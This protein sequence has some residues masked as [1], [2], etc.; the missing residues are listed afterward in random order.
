[1]PALKAA[2]FSLPDSK[3][4]STGPCRLEKLKYN[5]ISLNLA[6]YLLKIRFGDYQKGKIYKNA[7]DKTM[8][9]WNSIQ[10]KELF[11]KAGAWH[12]HDFLCQSLF[13]EMNNIKH[14]CTNLL[15]GGSSK[16]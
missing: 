1:M 6:Q 3:N 10:H 15:S 8:I 13:S 7:N 12:F 14:S 4:L 9:T 5:V 2:V 16:A 11:K